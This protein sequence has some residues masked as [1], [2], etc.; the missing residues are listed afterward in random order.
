MTRYDVVV[1]GATG[2]TGAY[3]VGR[4]ATDQL[5]KVLFYE[6]QKTICFKIKNSGLKKKWMVYFLLFIYEKEFCKNYFSKTLFSGNELC[7]G[8]KKRVEDQEN[9]GRSLQEDW[10]VYFL[11]MIGLTREQ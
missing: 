1:Y 7:R 10:W 11:I 5:C 4:L 6:F 3:I 2:Y 8:R 9:A